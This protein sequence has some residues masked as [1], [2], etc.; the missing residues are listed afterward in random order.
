M[1][2]M[3]SARA[4]HQL[5]RMVDTLCH[6]PFYNSGIWTEESLG[7]Y[8]GWV[9][10]DNAS[11]MPL[12]NRR[13]DVTLVFSGEEFTS[14][15]QP[16]KAN[17]AAS[18][19]PNFI[20]DSYS[21]NPS[22]LRTLNGRF[23]GLLVDRTKKSARLFNDRYGMHRVYW[24]QSK[25]GF[26]FGAE[27]KAILTVCPEARQLDPRSIGEFVACGSVL[28]NRSLFKGIRLLPGASDWSFSNG[29]VEKRLT[30]FDT[31]EWEQQERLD[32]EAY[33]RE[34]RQTFSSSLS[35]YFSGDQ[36][37]GMSLTGGLDTR[38]IMAWSKAAPGSLPCYT[39]AGSL[40]E[41]KDVEIARQ[42]AKA[43]GQSHQVV[44]VGDEF[45]SRFSY[46]AER[47]VYLTD[48]CVD[49]SRAP[50]LYLN[51]IAR[52]IAPVRMTGNYGS[53]VLRGVRA[54]KAVNP[55][56]GIFE[57]ELLDYV[58]AAKH[59]YSRLAAEHPV[60]FAVFK[61]L[62]W[63]H[64][65]ILALEETQLS[66]RS[67]FLDNDLVRAVFRAPSLSLARND[68]S[69]RL[70]GDGKE[71]LLEIPTDRG[72]AGA[73]SAFSR[74]AARALLEFSFKAEY[75]YDMGMPQ[76]LARIDHT[77]S[78]LKLE[79]LFLGRHKIFHFRSWYR[80]SCAPYVREMLL[81]SRSL[82]RPYIK[83]KGI[84]T[85]VDA[86]LKGTGN[87]TAEIHQILTLEL[88]NRLFLDGLEKA[89]SWEARKVLPQQV[90]CG[91]A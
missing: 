2:K 33:Y 83:P 25:D 42:V 17:R 63:H 91:I 54:F 80:N 21:D 14:S 30:Y 18:D 27:A 5:E 85:A 68:V 43:C 66:L 41:C 60:S 49:V 40:R 82:S 37:I 59:N 74:A 28:D 79:R 32:S 77:L 26:Y 72:G 22:F 20:A 67:P 48:G 64:Y 3:P 1:T 7:V 88:V 57:P 10:R 89:G 50:D 70:I 53:E 62:P 90:H 51:E 12:S 11:P 24:Y 46:Y 44:T 16:Q 55:A 61:Q 39:F 87:Y 56:P 47:A 13:G 58:D 35:R 6:E 73:G 23:H 29:T 86:H 9:A 81:D 45:L 78:A 84:E 69:R 38:L 65:G 71:G 31:E 76:W 8:V 4:V 36:P 34:L 75:A 19:G 15:S 52:Q